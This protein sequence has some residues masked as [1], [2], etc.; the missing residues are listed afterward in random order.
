M[1]QEI[2]VA[3]QAE[4]PGGL[5]GGGWARGGGVEKEFVKLGVGGFRVGLRFLEYLVISIG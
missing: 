3:A 4:F 5:G 1:A 2:E